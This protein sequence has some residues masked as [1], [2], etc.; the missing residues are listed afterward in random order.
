MMYALGDLLN[1][2]S[3]SLGMLE[4]ARFD[5]GS[6]EIAKVWPRC[7]RATSGYAQGD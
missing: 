1:C 3:G 6:Y 7:I 4:V 5:L 2:L